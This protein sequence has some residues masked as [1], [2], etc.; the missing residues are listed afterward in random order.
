LSVSL[1]YT[2]NPKHE[3]RKVLFY[4]ILSY[5]TLDRR[6]GG[7]LPMY[8]KKCTTTLFRWRQ[9]RQTRVNNS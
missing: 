1:R 9:Q 8:Y 7:W 4:C 3:N 2:R 6:E 5:L